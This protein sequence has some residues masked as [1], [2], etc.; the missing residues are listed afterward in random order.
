MGKSACARLLR[1]QGVRV[2]DTDD[3][4]RDLVQ[5]GQPALREISEAFGASILNEAGELRRDTMA[6]IIFQEVG[7]RQKLEA[8]LHPRI[9]AA[10][11]DQL[12]QWRH[13]DVSRAVVV[14]PLLFET[15]AEARFDSVICVACSAG[16]QRSRLGG[17]GWSEAELVRREAAQW[18]IEQKLARA[19]RVIWTEGSMAAH[20]EQVARVFGLS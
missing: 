12:R 3:L 19:H 5:P 18:P 2:I 10:W 15:A 8:I 17:R 16:T 13:G 1:E 9:T 11:A 4:A 7:A 20:A 14:I 6:D